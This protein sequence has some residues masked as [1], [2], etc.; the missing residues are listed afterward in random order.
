MPRNQPMNIVFPSAG[1]V[2]RF[3]LRDSTGGRGPF[4]APWAYN[5]RLEDGLTNRLRGGSFTAVAADTKADPVYRDRAISFSSNIITAARQGNSS[6]TTLSVDV[7][8]TR[9]PIIFQLALAD[10][11]GDTVVAVIPHKD[12]YL[13]C[14]TATETWV[15]AGDPA[16]GNL[17][18]VS[19]QVGIV[20][21]SAW[22]VNH[23][24]VY[25]LSSYGLYSVGADGSGLKPVSEDRVPEDLTGI[26]DSDAVLDYYHLDRG[27]YIHLT[28]S[29]SWFYDTAR[30][31]FWPFDRSTE[32]SHLLLGPFHL[33]A[34]ENSYGRI[35]NLHGNMAAGSEDVTWRIVTGLTAEEAAANGKAAIAAYVA[36][37][38]YSGYV[39]ASGV[40]SAGR[41]HMTYPRTRA[42]WCCI[43]LA[44]D[45]GDWAY[46]A[47]AMTR[48][49]SGK[50]R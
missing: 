17:R 7:S 36:G 30:D 46:E 2:R 48:V 12:A 22:C 44:V 8:D 35:Q 33:G 13:L 15:L 25:F 18:R 39:A 27:V 47:I 16:T 43:W 3:G 5:V 24:T 28:E 49:P 26:E 10:E 42:I 38:D 31:Q 45:S 14:F 19:D 34:T 32:E 21:A 20:G 4:P 29:P 50:W 1:V 6:D 37:G 40:W 41:S 11:T 9:R 23:D